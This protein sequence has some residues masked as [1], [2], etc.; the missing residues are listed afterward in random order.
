MP[1]RKTMEALANYLGTNYEE[2]EN[3]IKG[4]VN[5]YTYYITSQPTDNAITLHFAVSKN[6]EAPDENELESLTQQ[7]NFIADIAINN[8]QMAFQIIPG[9][10]PET[11][12]TTVKHAI[13]MIVH[14]FKENQYQN[15]DQLSGEVGTTDIHPLGTEW[16]LTT[17]DSMPETSAFAGERIKKQPREKIGRGIIGAIL[18]S[19]IGVILIIVISHFGY[20]ASISGFVLGIGAVKGYQYFAKGFSVKGLFVVLFV[21]IA[22]TYLAHQLSYAI[23]LADYVEEPILDTFISIPELLTEDLLDKGI[24]FGDFF[25]LLIYT[26]LGGIGT[27]FS[28]FRRIKNQNIKQ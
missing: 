26:L 28:E 12:E 20:I 10:S 21:M 19:L 3:L 6:G 15:T 5:G 25:K 11:V 2:N 18:G 1:D 13:Q 4:N 9:A 14:Y 8:Y 7:Y 17:N 23:P 16:V 22:M 27:L 24:Y